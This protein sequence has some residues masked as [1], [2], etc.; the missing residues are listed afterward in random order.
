[1]LSKSCTENEKNEQIPYLQLVP[2]THA[3]ISDIFMNNI[4][5]EKPLD[6]LLVALLGCCTWWKCRVSFPL[7]VNVHYSHI[8]GGDDDNPQ[9]GCDNL[10]MGQNEATYFSDV[11]S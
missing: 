4:Y 2:T 8:L 10:G 5:T 9:S 1:M 7:Q 6:L 11:I 3:A